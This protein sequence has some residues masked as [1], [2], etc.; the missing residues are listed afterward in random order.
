MKK[1]C[2]VQGGPFLLGIDCENVIARRTWAETAAQTEQKGLI[3]QLDALL[4]QQAAQAVPDEAVC[5]EL[6]NGEERVFL[7]ADRIAADEVE[8]INPP[9]PLPSACP[10]LTARLCPQVTIWEELPVLLLEPTQL[11]ATALELGQN[12]GVRPPAKERADAQAAV[13]EPEEDDPFFP[14]TEEEEAEDAPSEPQAAMPF[15]LEN[16]LAESANSAKADEPEQLPPSQEAQKKESAAIDEETFKQVM[17][18]TVTRFKQSRRG[19]E[20]HLGVE[21]LP[22]EL[23][24]MIKRKGLNKNVIEYLMEQIVLRCKETMSRKKQGGSDAE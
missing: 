21:Q 1:V 14:E 20:L 7:I 8:I 11:V 6:R 22:S 23:A 24:G 15:F 12:I 2:I 17:S 16:A 10:A 5:L 19:Q 4:S 13:P 3:F 9:G 18:W